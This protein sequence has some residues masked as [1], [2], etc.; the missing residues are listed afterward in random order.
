MSVTTPSMAKMIAHSIISNKVNKT[1]YPATFDI[2]CLVDIH[3]TEKSRAS[4]KYIV[5]SVPSDI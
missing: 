1:L 3:I 2:T 4:Y 5:L